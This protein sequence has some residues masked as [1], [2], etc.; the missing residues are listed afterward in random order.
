LL[1]ARSL[2]GGAQVCAE[3]FE[4]GIADELECDR[5]SAMA[6]LLLGV[7][8][9]RGD[10]FAHAVVIVLQRHATRIAAR[11]DQVA[12]PQ[13]RHAA[14]ELRGRHLRRGQQHLLGQR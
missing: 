2:A 8:Q 4:V 10:R 14:G 3:A 6:L 12:H 9:P 7:G 11:S 1:A 13:D 5:E